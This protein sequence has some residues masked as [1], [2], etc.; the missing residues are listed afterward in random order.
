MPVNLGHYRKAIVIRVSAVCSF[1]IY[2][3][4]FKCNLRI[5]RLAL[6]PQLYGIHMRITSVSIIVPVEVSN[7][8][9]H[10]RVIPIIWIVS[11]L[12]RRDK[13]QVVF[14]CTLDCSDISVHY[15]HGPAKLKMIINNRFKIGK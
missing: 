12:L 13:V 5:L 10:V 14:F 2:A 9:W 1:Q 6:V 15:C 11:G 3:R 4:A 7:K 8:H